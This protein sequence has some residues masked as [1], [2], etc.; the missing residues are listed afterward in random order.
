[1]LYLNEVVSHVAPGRKS[2]QNLAEE[3]SLTPQE[4]SVFR[5]V[6]G[7]RE[8]AVVDSEGV[9]EL[10]D[11]SLEKMLS[12]PSVDVKQIKYVFHCHAAPCVCPSGGDLIGRLKRKHGLEHAVS[13]GLAQDQCATPLTA[14]RLAEV[15]LHAES[16]DAKVLLL[17]G[18]VGFSPRLRLIPNTTIIGDASAACLVGKRGSRNAVLAVAQRKFE[19]ASVQ[20]S[21][22]SFIPVP[23]TSYGDDLLQVVRDALA[24]AAL[25]IDELSVIL[26]HNVNSI[27]WKFFARNFPC[28]ADLIYLDNVART[29]HCFTS[30]PFINY[31][32]ALRSNRLK[33]GD[34]FMMVSVGTTSTFAAVV[35]RH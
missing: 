29:G 22:G 5:T 2:V 34:H 28:S 24:Q 21:G 13:V 11:T 15:L 6:F 8:I 20:P 32:D 10:L 3:L 14:L 25:S 26:V 16:D 27:S 19:H 7:L 30:D 33:E 17:T 1:M 9:F 35:L 12:N 18:E 23:A 4:V 31:C